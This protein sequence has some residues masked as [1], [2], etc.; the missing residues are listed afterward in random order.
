M[1]TVLRCTDHITSICGIP[2]ET[3][4]QDVEVGHH[5]ACRPKDNW[6]K[7]TPYE[8]KHRVK[9]DEGGGNWTES[10]RAKV[11]DQ[12]SVDVRRGTNGKMDGQD[13]T[14]YRSGPRRPRKHQ[15]AASNC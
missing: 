10:S 4:A 1:E 5:E 6:R 8:T 7:K 14:K 9:T 2:R 12:R 13:K 11:K 15:V 3:E